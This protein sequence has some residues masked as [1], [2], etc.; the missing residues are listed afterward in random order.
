MN[1]LSQTAGVERDFIQTL[2]K[3]LTRLD[4]KAGE[5]EALQERRRQMQDH[6]KVVE[7][8]GKLAKKLAQ[9]NLSTEL[10]SLK[11]EAEKGGDGFTAVLTPLDSMLSE[12]TEL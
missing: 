7:I 3:D 5:E 6:H 2:V 4:P 8:A 11:R 9:M 12:L 1:N 10:Y